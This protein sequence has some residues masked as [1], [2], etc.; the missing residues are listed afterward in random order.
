VS[1]SQLSK[2][3]AGASFRVGPLYVGSGSVLSALL[4]S[5]HQLDGFVGVRFG[6]LQKRK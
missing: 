5:S 3:N 1:Y 6:G 2:L 4:G